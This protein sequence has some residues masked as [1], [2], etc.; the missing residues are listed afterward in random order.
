MTMQQR[1]GW[2]EATPRNSLGQLFSSL[3][4]GDRRG[5]H[6]PHADRRWRPETMQLEDR[7]LLAGFSSPVGHGFT[8]AQIQT[9]YGINAIRLDG[10]IG[11]GAGQT[12]AIVDQYNDPTIAH[13]LQAFD[14]AFDLPAPPSFTVV[15]SDGQ[16]APLPTMLATAEQSRETALDVEWAHAVAPMASIVLVEAQPSS[17]TSVPSDLLTAIRTAASLPGVTVV[18]M[19][20]GH[21][22]FNG[23]QNLDNYFTTPP[24]HPNVTFVA[25]TGDSTTTPFAGE[26]PA[27]SPN[28]VAV[29]GTTL[30]LTSSGG[31]VSETAWNGSE[32]GFSKYETRP[33]YQ[34][35]V[36]PFEGTNPYTATNPNPRTVPD[37]S[38]DA[39]PNT[40]VAIYDSTGNGPT[41]PWSVEGGTSLGAPAWAALIATA[42]QLRQS[43]GEAPLTSSQT[44]Q[45][46]YSLPAADFHKITSGQNMAAAAAGGP[47]SAGGNYNLVTGLGSPVANV[48]VPDL[49]APVLV[50]LQRAGIHQHS[51]LDLSFLGALD[52]G[53]AQ[54]RYNYTLLAEGPNGLFNHHIRLRSATYHAVTDTVA[55]VPTRLPLN[56]TY[57]LLVRGTPPH[58]L[59][60]PHGIFLAGLK[61]PHGVFLAGGN[62]KVIFSGFTPSSP[63]A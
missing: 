57:E 1:L 2:Q 8:P 58:G 51:T 23:E 9:A 4:R 54:D 37:V 26:Y 12:I 63:V 29:G 62:Q 47:F 31:Y 20:F 3:G 61:G 48:L 60:G 14:A 32:G 40:G 24:G 52:P 45:T 19:S 11:N 28:V 59:R 50:S 42:D 36:Q 21:E 49:A 41:T 35:G 30:T 53:S 10:V 15:N 5:R 27:F 16:T 33:S 55:L 13:D 7:M 46:L 22:E 56:Y 43:V 44:L 39:N 38:F 34:N 18:S 17:F 25:S 6:K